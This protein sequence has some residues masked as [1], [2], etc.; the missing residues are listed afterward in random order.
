MTTIT[1]ANQ[2]LQA[3]ANNPV[4]TANTFSTLVNGTITPVGVLAQTPNVVLLSGA[5]LPVTTVGQTSY[6][7]VTPNNVGQSINVAADRWLEATPSRFVR[8]FSPVTTSDSIFLSKGFTRSLFDYYSASDQILK[9]ISKS[10]SDNILSIS[11]NTKNLSKLY[12][13][14]I[15]TSS[16]YSRVL[17]FSRNI[18]SLPL[19]QSI[20]DI[21]VSK[22]ISS[23]S[24]IASSITKGISIEEVSI[25]T[26]VD[27]LS[28]LVTF[29]RSSNSVVLPISTISSNYNK[30][31]N[32]SNTLSISTRSI[33]VG[34]AISS[35]SATSFSR[36]YTYSKEVAEVLVTASTLSAIKAYGRELSSSILLTSTNSKLLSKNNI[37]SSVV[38][39][40]FRTASIQSYFGEN[41]YEADYYGTQYTI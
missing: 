10:T 32:T 8:G 33:T 28:R 5:Y 14:S 6:T 21:I 38:V 18:T 35:S 9:N 13:S 37:L 22:S 7:P 25:S 31:A 26:S 20:K 12:N 34:K 11:T 39:T 17:G 40:E 19:T 3:I 30:L 27:D 15:G 4:V 29:I 36:S 23:S 16:I 24:I 2:N 41:Y 1:I